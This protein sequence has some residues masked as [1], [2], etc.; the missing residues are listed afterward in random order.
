MHESLL[1]IRAKL[2]FIANRLADV[3]T[4]SNF[5]DVIKAVK[6]A[7]EASAE[8]SKSAIEASD[9]VNKLPQ[10][11]LDKIEKNQP[12]LDAFK[13]INHLIRELLKKLEGERKSVTAH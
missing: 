12:A 4:D 2:E 13:E 11:L 1:L 8:L 5:Q 3:G 7:T 9:A 6:T 10:E